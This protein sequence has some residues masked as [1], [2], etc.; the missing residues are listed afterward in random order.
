MVGL[1]ARLVLQIERDTAACWD[2][3]I[4]AASADRAEDPAAGFLV[5][6]P[7][8][9]RDFHPLASGDARVWGV[10]PVLPAPLQRGALLLAGSLPDRVAAARA[11]S[12]ARAQV[13]VLLREHLG[14]E[15]AWLAESVSEKEV[16]PCLSVPARVSPLL[17]HWAQR[18]RVPRALLAPPQ[19]LVLSLREPEE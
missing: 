14:A 7:E 2:H 18:V 4:V 12:V 11:R 6:C 10:Q 15:P 16:L 8:P 9:V 3:Q 13:F 17:V 19:E 5:S 1:L